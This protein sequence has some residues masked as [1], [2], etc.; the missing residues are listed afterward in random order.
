MSQVEQQP[1]MKP[2]RK[3]FAIVPPAVVEEFSLFF[4][5][6][7]SQDIG[8]VRYFFHLTDKKWEELEAQDES[9]VCEDT[10]FSNADCFAAVMDAMCHEQVLLPGASC[11]GLGNRLLHALDS[12]NSTNPDDIL[13]TNRFRSVLT[14]ALSKSEAARK[15]NDAD[16]E[17]DGREIVLPEVPEKEEASDCREQ[18]TP[19]ACAKLKK[20]LK[21]FR[22]FSEMRGK[23]WYI[24]PQKS[25]F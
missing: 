14:W 10:P 23:F 15:L 16:D 5:A 7:A 21:I 22:V 20:N 8:F 19:C 1:G 9:V 11:G 2:I 6:M 17:F 4:T 25:K 3:T 18:L 13:A 24:D 12:S